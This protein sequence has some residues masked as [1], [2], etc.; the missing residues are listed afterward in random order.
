MRILGIDLSL[1]NTGLAVIDDADDLL[2]FKSIKTTPKERDPSRMDRIKT[3]VIAL[4]NTCEVV[5]LERGVFGPHS[6]SRVH[7]IGGLIKWALW[8]ECFVEGQDLI[9]VSPMTVKKFATGSGRADKNDMLMAAAQRY[10]FPRDHNIADAIHIAR[11]VA[12]MI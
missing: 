11:L 6:D 5:G 10:T 4:A 8:K 9:I 7:E 3:E 2:D 1:T 12:T